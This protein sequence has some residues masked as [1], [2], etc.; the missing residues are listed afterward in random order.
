MTIANFISEKDQKF[1][2]VCYSTSSQES[3]EQHSGH[4]G[5]CRILVSFPLEWVQTDRQDARAVTCPNVI[6]AWTE[7]QWDNDGS[8]G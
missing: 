1:T 6:N 8:I 2:L 4:T 3:K 5:I 7:M